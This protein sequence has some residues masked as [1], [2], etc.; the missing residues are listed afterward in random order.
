MFLKDTVSSCAF[1]APISWHHCPDD[2]N[3]SSLAERWPF[4]CALLAHSREAR[5][6]GKWTLDECFCVVL[7]HEDSVMMCN[8]FLRTSGRSQA[9]TWVENSGAW[10]IVNHR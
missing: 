6:S 7:I 9:A 10:R 5:P 4:Y 1:K 8:A 2:P 3:S